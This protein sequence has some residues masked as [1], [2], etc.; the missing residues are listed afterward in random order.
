MAF[1]G[2]HFTFQREFPI[3]NLQLWQKTE[4]PKNRVPF[5]WS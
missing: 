3:P 4:M 5:T 1:F 2:M